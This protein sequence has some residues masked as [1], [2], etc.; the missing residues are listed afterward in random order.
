M[1]DE[2]FLFFPVL[3]A[4]NDE[5]CYP[6]I[7]TLNPKASRKFSNF[8]E[9]LYFICS[10]T[11]PVDPSGERKGK[12]ERERQKESSCEYRCLMVVWKMKP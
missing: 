10:P 8:N 4:K 2:D 9:P 6:L 1:I 7:C 5:K 12:R 3:F 11:T